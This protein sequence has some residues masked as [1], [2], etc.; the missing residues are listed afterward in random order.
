MKAQWA[1]G[2]VMAAGLRAQAQ[3]C[4]VDVYILKHVPTPA[5]RLLAASRLMTTQMFREI[6]VSLRMQD[7]YPPR[8]TSHACGAPIV[9]EFENADRIPSRPEAVAYATPYKESGTCIHIFLD[10]V[11]VNLSREPA[12]ANALLAHV[13]AHEIT[14]VLEKSTRHSKEGVMKAHWSSQDYRRME[15]DPLPFAPGDVDLIRQGIAKRT[16]HDAAE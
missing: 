9:I 12:L 13:L 2:I 6:G 15:R 10:R 4:S 7:G 8:D 11:L 14:H 1:I 16:A 3:D 5:G